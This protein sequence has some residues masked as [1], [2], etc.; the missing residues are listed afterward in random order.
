MRHLLALSLLAAVVAASTAFCEPVAVVLPFDPIMDSLYAPL[1]GKESV[2]SYQKALQEMLSSDLGKHIEIRVVELSV[3]DN[4]LKS[5][6]IA[7]DR[8][9]D[10][11]LAGR[12]A[13][14]VGADYAIIGTYG[15]FTNEIRVDA[16]VA[17]AATGDVPPGNTVTATATIWE[18]LP[19][20]ASMISAGILPIVT[21]SGRIRPTSKAV[22]FPEGDISAYD[23]NGEHP[24]GMARLVVWVNTPAP[25][26]ESSPAATFAR[27]SRIDRMNIPS[28][29]QVSSTCQFALVRAGRI[30]LSVTN[31]GFLPYEEDL[32]L[33]AGKA[34]RLQVDLKPVEQMPR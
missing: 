8:W 33:E 17:V 34:Y 1:G 13:G 18:D 9:N 23:P 10:P 7:P 15:E 14:A 32:T 20:A 2:L 30:T 5:E 26:I 3:F 12:I 21:A 11:V 24:E 6:R 27:C 16:R 28:E 25:K 29:Q 31:R 19:S 4:Y 22:L